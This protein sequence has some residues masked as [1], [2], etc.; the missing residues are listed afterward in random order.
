MPRFSLLLSLA[1]LLTACQQAPAPTALPLIDFSSS[2]PIAVNASEIR[3]V[4][5]YRS[6][7]QAP[8]VEHL[9]P[10]PPI[11]AIKRWSEQRLRAAGSK[12]ILEI[13]VDDAS[14]IEKKLPKTEGMRGFFTDDQA[15]RYDARINVTLRLY[16]GERAVSDA[17][18]N[19][20][21]IRARSI[22]EKATVVERERF[23]HQMLTDMM[24]QFDSEAKTRLSQYFSPY[25]V[26]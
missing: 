22:N 6:P 8:H 1:A 10:T 14:V 15:E 12:G 20:S 18:G 16:S 2:P 3:V 17:E 23:F 26:R 21:V 7:L 24:Q 13:V 9:F 25:L 19:V 11:A 5:N 4:E